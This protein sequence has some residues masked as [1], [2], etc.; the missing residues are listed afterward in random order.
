VPAPG[1]I[2]DYS[3]RGSLATWTRVTAVRIALRMRSRRDP[4]AEVPDGQPA[5]VADPELRFLKRRYGKH[6][7][8]ALTNAFARLDH[9]Q[10][11]LLRL[12]LVDG[13]GTAEIAALFQLNRS[14]IKRRLAA[15]REALF[16]DVQASLARELGVSPRS[17]GSL[18][19]LL[20]SQLELSLPR[21]LRRAATDG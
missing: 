12:Q 8:R 7:E 16:N 17:F 18:A 2:V 3:G 10:H 14:T 20:T 6:F 4:L 9:E 5:A 11:N 13:L 19:R 1:R 21:L 15:C